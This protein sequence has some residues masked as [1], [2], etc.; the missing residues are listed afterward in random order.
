VTTEGGPGREAAI[1]RC[2]DAA[3]ALGYPPEAS[4]ALV[5]YVEAVLSE[6]ERL[7][8]TAARDLDTALPVLG[9][10]SLPVVSAAG[11]SAPRV[12]VD[13]GSGN[14]LP[15]VAVAL[16]WPG[17]SVRLVERRAKKAAA[18]GRALAASGVEN[19][20]A[21]AC[22]S[23]ELLA[24][25]PGLRGRVDLVTARAVGPLDAVARD[26][27]PW[28]APGGRILHWKPDAVDPSE[29]E[30]GAR[31]A[32]SLGLSVLE[33]HAFRVP[34]APAPRRIVRYERPR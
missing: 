25:E 3:R 28:L 4:A 30:A 26:A 23:R 14:G 9:L 24:R 11:V 27:A 19:A 33:D 10:D 2:E 12:A 31:T 1:R 7:N 8:L 34:G 18:V 5:R 13:V 32:R 20:R 15:G 17:V 22:D 21:V 16:A 29:R 6:G